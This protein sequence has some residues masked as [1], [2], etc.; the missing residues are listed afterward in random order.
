[1]PW[2]MSCNDDDSDGP[3]CSDSVFVKDND[4]RWKFGPVASIGCRNFMEFAA[5]HEWEQT[6]ITTI[7][8]NGEEI[9]VADPMKYGAPLHIMITPN[10]IIDLDAESTEAGTYHYDFFHQSIPEGV[11]IESWDPLNTWVETIGDRWH[12]GKLSLDM[13]NGIAVPSEM[14]LI[15]YQPTLCIRKMKPKFQ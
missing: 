14:S 6:S 15:D 9:A 1:M 4:G 7:N 2:I 13:A 5:N 12:P 11:L 3:L 8:D 10:A